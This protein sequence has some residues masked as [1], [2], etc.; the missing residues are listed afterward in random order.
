MIKRVL[1]VVVMPV[2]TPHSHGT[3]NNTLQLHLKKFLVPP[4]L[5]GVVLGVVLAS[6]SPQL[7]IVPQVVTVR[8]P[9]HPLQLW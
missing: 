7:A 9:N 2:G 1:V 5:L 8:L 6:R 4:A 3:A